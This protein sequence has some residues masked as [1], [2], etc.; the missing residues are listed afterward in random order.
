MQT[1]S[2]SDVMD[3][4]NIET[5]LEVFRPINGDVDVLREFAASVTYHLNPGRCDH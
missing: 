1:R 4:D 5:S 2:M 3:P